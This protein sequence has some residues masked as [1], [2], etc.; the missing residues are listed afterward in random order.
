MQLRGRLHRH[1]L[2][3]TI[4]KSGITLDLDWN[5]ID[6][7]SSGIDYGVIINDHNHIKIKNGTIKDHYDGVRIRDAEWVILYKLHLIEN[8]DGGVGAEET[9]FL[10]LD[11][12]RANSNGQ[13]SSDGDGANI[14][15]NSDYYTLK[16][17]KFNNNESDGVEADDSHHGTIK[18]SEDNDNGSDGFDVDDN[19]YGRVTHSKADDNYDEAFELDDADHMT[20]TLQRRHPHRRR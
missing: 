1:L 11:Y 4:G 17:S 18:D 15:T 20:I 5:E 14:D 8:D 10:T 12:V 19:D 9:R 3:I 7:N 2:G 13:D 6:G 16:H